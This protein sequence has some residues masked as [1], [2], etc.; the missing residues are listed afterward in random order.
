M[1]KI[2]IINDEFLPVLH[3]LED[4]INISFKNETIKAL[5]DELFK[6]GF[7]IRGTVY[8][9][10]IITFKS[11]KRL[12]F[13]ELDTS[14]IGIFKELQFSIER[15]NDLLKFYDHRQ[16][17]ISYSEFYYSFRELRICNKKL[18]ILKNELGIEKIIELKK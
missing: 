2:T 17:D 12:S 6:I 1:D 7:D 9:L 18:D 4:G 11:E 16:G 10:H 15:I 13:Y 14:K 5:N 8:K 3:S